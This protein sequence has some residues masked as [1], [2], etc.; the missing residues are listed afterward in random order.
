M[1]SFKPVFIE[2]RDINDT[3]F[4]LLQALYDKGRPVVKTAG[5]GEG[6]TFYT[7]DFVSGFIHY[8]HTRPLAPIMPEGV[9]PITTDD[10]I[11]EYFTTYLMDSDLEKNEHY[12]YSTWV[13][14]GCGKN[15][16]T[17]CYYISQIEWIINHFKSKGYSNNHCYLTVGN[18]EISLE[19]N[20]PYKR[21]PNCGRLYNN[22]KICPKCKAGLEVD[23]S[24]RPTTPCL[25]GLDF[26]IIDGY[27][28]TQIIYRAWNSLAWPENMGGFVLLNEYVADQLG[29]VKPGPLSFSCKSL[30]CP[31]DTFDILKMRLRK[32]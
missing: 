3:W 28:T 15:D 25:R 1:D 29:D 12:R 11:E 30:N 19:Y 17:S 4:Q 8:P 21:C 22:H 32:E 5:S 20:K 13:V 26:R 9:P 6:M 23:E 14:G 2:G 27:L 24:E 10:K 31:E 18:P 16:H 7:L